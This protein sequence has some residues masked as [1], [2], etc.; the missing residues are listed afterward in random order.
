MHLTTRIPQS[1]RAATRTELVAV[2]TGLMLCGGLAIPAAPST[3]VRSVRVQCANNLKWLG[4]AS[5]GYADTNAG[6]FPTLTGASWP[7]DMP[8]ATANRL[9]ENG[10]NRQLFYCPSV[11]AGNNDRLWRFSSGA[12]DNLASP[13]VGFRIVGYQFAFAGSGR[14]KTTNLTTSLKPA[15]WVIN[16]LTNNPPLSE[17][18]IVADAILSQGDNELNRDQNTYGQIQGAVGQL[19]SAHLNGTLPGGGN[20]CFADGHVTWRP[21][22]EMHV[23]TSGGPAFWW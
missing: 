14:V 4:A 12:D 11:P 13:E 16:G 22:L 8:T 19:Q 5:I 17:R 20:L 10:A 6:R 2:I 21:F 3:R 18:V 1:A 23:R 7:W 15:P 9:V